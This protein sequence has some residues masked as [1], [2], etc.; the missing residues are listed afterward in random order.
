MI[1][2]FGI[3]TDLLNPFAVDNTMI[4]QYLANI[5]N[6]TLYELT[7]DLMMI[8]L[9][10][11]DTGYGDLQPLIHIIRN[12]LQQEIVIRP[13]LPWRERLAFRLHV[14]WQAQSTR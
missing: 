13:A 8:W 12:S 7:D 5:Y 11:P 9:C 3:S 1:D 10:I 2:E 6:L 4:E 14:R